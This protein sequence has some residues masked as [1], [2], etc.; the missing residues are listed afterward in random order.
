MIDKNNIL[1]ADVLEIIFDGRN[2]TYGA[3]ELRTNYKK[4][5]LISV[6]GMIMI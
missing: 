5:L 1:Q 4:R 2:K 3:Y 6:T